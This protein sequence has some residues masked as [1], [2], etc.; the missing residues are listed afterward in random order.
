MF[1]ALQQVLEPYGVWYPVVLGP[2]AIA[3]ARSTR[4]GLWGPVTGGRDVRFLPT[5]YHVTLPT[6]PHP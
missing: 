5:G 6:P 3:A 2:V 1:F 4:R